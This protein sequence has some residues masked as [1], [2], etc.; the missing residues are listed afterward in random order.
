MNWP[1]CSPDLSPIEIYCQIL[2]REIGEIELPAGSSEVKKDFLWDMVKTKWEEL[3]VGWGPEIIK[4]YCDT[5]PHRMT[6]MR[7]AAGGS[8][9]Y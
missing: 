7:V 2:K 4:K 1:A 9:K 5:M 3:K 6:V 8:T